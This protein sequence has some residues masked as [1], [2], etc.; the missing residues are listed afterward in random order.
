MY[1]N[2]NRHP[3]VTTKINDLHE[4]SQ[5]VDVSVILLRDPPYKTAPNMIF[6]HMISKFKINYSLDSLGIWC[7]YVTDVSYPMF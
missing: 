4:N 7:V 5:F 3:P 1:N 6:S 2:V